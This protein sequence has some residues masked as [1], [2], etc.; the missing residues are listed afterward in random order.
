[1]RPI[2]SIIIHCTATPITLDIGVDEVRLWHTTE[3]NNWSDIGY[4]Y[5]IRRNAAVEIGRPIEQVG[6]HAVGY[7]TRSIGIALVGGVDENNEPE[8]NFTDEQMQVLRHTIDA[9]KYIYGDLKVIG[10]RD[11]PG[12]NKACPCFDVH[13]WYYEDSACS[14]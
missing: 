6:A 12:V 9:L 13:D 11:L 4:H 7:N 3:P 10:H 14:E 5:V 2:D 1:M 8:M